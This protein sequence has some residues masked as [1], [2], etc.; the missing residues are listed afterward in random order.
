MKSKIRPYVTAHTRRGRRRVRFFC[1]GVICAVSLVGCVSKSRYE[2]VAIEM[3][4]LRADLARAQ[5]EVHALEQQRDTL[6]KLNLDGER[7]LTTIRT[8][9]QRARAGYEEYK[10]EQDRLNGLRAKAKAL[11][12]EQQKHMQ[13][14]KA[15]KR[16]ELKMQ[17][18]IDRYEKD[19][20][21]VSDIGD[22]LRVS[23]TAEPKDDGSRLVATVTP[24]PEN[25]SVMANAST[26]ASQPASPPTS[27]PQVTAG[28]AVSPAPAVVTAPPPASTAPAQTATAKPTAAPAPKPQPAPV[29]ESWIGSLTG[30]LSSMWGWLFS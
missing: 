3:D 7:L 13:G 11:Q 21:Q 5:T 28:A 23:Q 18:V 15:A 9:L 29:G 16:E 30:W 26:S 14:I 10:A 6:A 24:L 12:S 22:V 8:E 19:M 20:Q 2:S 25:P 27:P 4:G 17:A 1:L